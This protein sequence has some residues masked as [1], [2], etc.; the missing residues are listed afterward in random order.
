MYS[1][2]LLDMFNNKIVFSI[3]TKTNC[4]NID[5]YYNIIQELRL[6][7]CSVCLMISRRSKHV[8]E[9]L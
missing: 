8:A 5:S 6:N 4:N 9:H 2:Y 3:K 1:V 7:S